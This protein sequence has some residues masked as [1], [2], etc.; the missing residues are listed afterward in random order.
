MNAS[1]KPTDPRLETGTILHKRYAVV[2]IL[3]SGDF[4][5]VYLARDKRATKVKDHVA[6]KEKHM[7]MSVDC[8]RQADLRATLLHPAIPRVLGYFVTDEHSC[9]VQELILGSDLEAV[10]EAHQGF[11]SE[12]T[13]VGWAIQL[14]DALDYLHNHPLHSII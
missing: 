12:K 11:L 2:K 8:E 5:V 9:L 4:G 10:L 13:V 6:I 1:T 3:G 7:Q 14:C